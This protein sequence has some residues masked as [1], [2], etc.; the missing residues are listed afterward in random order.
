MCAAGLGDCP[1]DCPIYNLAD[2]QASALRSHNIEAIV[3]MRPELSGDNRPDCKI[4]Q[5]QSRDE[6]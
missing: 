4:Y 3:N 2:L 1:T 6:L 5:Q